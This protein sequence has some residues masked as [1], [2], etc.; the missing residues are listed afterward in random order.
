MAYDPWEQGAQLPT[1]TYTQFLN[2]EIDPRLLSAGLSTGLALMQPPS[3]G[4]TFG[5]QL[6]RAIGTGA[7]ASQRAGEQATQHRVK[8]AQA[9]SAEARAD[10]AASRSGREADRAGYAAERLKLVREGQAGLNERSRLSALLRAQSQF[11]NEKALNPGLD[12]RTFLRQRNL[13]HL[14][15]PVAGAPNAPQGEDE[16]D[17]ATPAPPRALAPPAAV[18]ALRKDPSLAPQFDAKYGA[19]SARSVLGR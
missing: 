3:W 10:A 16:E 14:L 11:A 19:G 7:E 15:T 12:F 4:D 5:S 9:Y 18:D 8:E 17:T 13:E 6:A 2:G 1:D